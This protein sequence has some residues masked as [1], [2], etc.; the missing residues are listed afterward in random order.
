M[1]DNNENNDFND[2]EFDENGFDPTK[3]AFFSDMEEMEEEIGVEAY[4]LVAHALSLIDSKFFDD[5]IEVLRQAVGLYDQI[6]KVAEIEAIRNKISEI[7]IL[8]EQAFTEVESQAEEEVKTEEQEIPE[9]IVIQEIEEE[10]LKEKKEADLDYS[11]EDLINEANQLVEIDEFDEALDRYDEA[12]RIFEDSNNNSKIER[13]NKLIEEC[14]KAKASLLKVAKK[15]P[16]KVEMPVE[17]EPA[18]IISKDKIKE[19]RV[20]EFEE[21]K[22]REEQLSNQALELMGQALEKAKSVQY[23][24]AIKLYEDAA[25]LFEEINW[26]NE[27]TKVKATIGKIRKEKEVYLQRLEAEREER[28]KAAE[29]KRKEA[30]LLAKKAEERKIKEEDEK[31][32]KFEELGA[33]K[34]EEEAF[35]KLISNM[36]DNAEKRARDYELDIKKGKFDIKCPYEELIGIYEYIRK[37]LIDKG[38]NDQA[39]IYTKQVKLLHEKLEKDIKLRKIEAQKAQKQK[40]YDELYK[41]P[42]K[43]KQIGLDIERLKQ[44]EEQK[45]IDAEREVFEVEMSKK[46][47]DAERICRD[48]EIAIRKGKFETKCPYPEIIETYDNI[49]AAFQ[50]RGNQD[51]IMIYNN[52]INVTKQRLEKDNKLREI[53]AK[54][55]QKQKEYDELFKVKK[56]K[57]V[58]IDEEKLKAAEEQYKKELEEQDFINEIEKMAEDAE[59]MA[60]EYEVVIRKGK[61]ETICPYQE[62]IETYED[63]KEAFQERGNIDQISIYNNIINIIRGKLEKDNKLREIEAQKAKKQEEYEELYKGKKEVKVGL[64]EERL[65]VLE[66]QR[67]KELDEEN[68]RNEIEKMVSK[69]ERMAREYEVQ[70][71]KGKF[72]T[73]CVYADIINIFENIVNIVGKRGW[74][75]E[76][77]IYKTQI[78]RYNEKLEKDNKLREIEAKK[79]EKDRA[80]KELYK[81][82][83]VAKVGLDEERLKVL[84]EQRQ[85]ELDEENFRNEIEKMIMNAEKMAREYEVQI[86]KGNFEQECVYSEIMNTFENIVNIVSERGWQDEA[87]IY[88][89]QIR[90]YK[91]KLE[92]DNKLRKIEAQ[93]LQKQKDFDELHKIKEVDTIRAVIKSLDREEQMLDVFEK[94]REQNYLTDKAMTVIDDAEKLV[95]NYELKIKKEIFLYDSPYEEVISLYKE[96]RK[97]FI[98]ADWRDEASRLIATIKFYM[99][100][101][102]KDDKLRDLEESKREKAK[103]EAEAMKVQPRKD[104]IEKKK[105]VLELEHRKKEKELESDEIF[106]MINE[107]ERLVKEYELTIKGGEILQYECPYE[108][109]IKIYREAKKRLGDIGWKDEANRLNSSINF[110]KQKLERDN[111]L[112]EVERKKIER[113]EMFKEIIKAPVKA[114][115]IK[116]EMKKLELKKEKSK[117]DVVASETFKMIDEAEK[118]V[119]EYELK[120]KAGTFLECPYESIIETYREARKKFEEIGWKDQAANL[121]NT[122]NHYK[123]KLAQDNKLRAIEAEKIA[124]EQEL[125]KGQQEIASKAR[126]QQMEMRKRKEEALSLQQRKVSETER[127]RNEAFSL[128]DKAKIEFNKQNF[129]EALELYTKSKEYFTQLDWQEGISMVSGSITLIKKKKKEM[130]LRQEAAKAKEAEKIEIEK[131]LEAKFAKIKDLKKI[132]EAKKKLELKKIQSEK[133]KEKEASDQAYQLLEQGTTL[134]GKKKFDEAQKKYINAR[135]IF[136]ELNWTR[137]VSRINNDLLFKLRREKK[138]FEGLKDLKKR[139]LEEKRVKDEL[140]KQSQIDKKESARK[141]IQEK[142]RKLKELEVTK[143]LDKKL[144]DTLDTANDF[145]NRGYYNQGIL[146]FEEVIT[147][148]EKK[149]LNEEVEKINNQINSVKSEAQLPLIISEELDR[150]ENMEKFKNAYKSIDNAQESILDGN[151]MKSISE[152]NEAKHNLKETKL[153]EKYIK[154]IDEKIKFCREELQKK[155]KKKAEPAKEIKKEELPEELT[156]DVAYNYMD[157]ANK[158]ERKNNFEKAV[159]FATMAR[160]IF[161]KL[162]LEWSREQAS[163]SQHIAI[164]KNKQEARKRLFTSAQEKREEKEEQLKSEEESKAK[165]EA[166]RAERRKRIQELMEKRSQNQK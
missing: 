123:T 18:E 80:Y 70:I 20:K 132:E 17:T 78:R 109:I 86:R 26:I 4:D 72:D 93:K 9:E 30:K 45:A 136:K 53:E 153:G 150:N 43:E 68:F 105:K 88:K 114:D 97:L 76:V 42:T 115:I 156:A 130:E 84:E 129:D 16:L 75:D 161:V 6:N 118:S 134:L 35:Q 64:D 32:K 39:V 142:R 44:F 47:D 71:R 120:L 81:G 149:G 34:L 143:S 126:A 14:Y 92:R 162:G 83:K 113:A 61:F 96:A 62:I 57:K 125:L 91:E 99:D 56:E 46:V 112:R 36:V 52:L 25:K 51:Q 124:K 13:V 74:Q 111:K 110:Y 164:L 63:I 65:K 107:A 77:A 29:M 33:K 89:T 82:K 24:D 131:K 166:R 66:E 147:L 2:E 165:I 160:D 67:Q 59:K 106:E 60:R 100:K 135:D 58:G 117:E 157:K 119:K 73:E 116:Q 41:A 133:A 144:R 28:E 152:L 22:K 122:I 8:K 48:Y 158:E 15:E 5:A 101:K 21:L 163:I 90:K 95:K 141:K 7:Y 121:I 151:Y 159:E 154:I 40:E 98:E 155:R 12:I 10:V 138:K 69:T 31:I 137:E 108:N 145:V 94:K 49:R 104:L 148:M 3:E 146:K 87:A 23:D 19:Q 140:F 139:K 1:G 54:K 11:V 85:K 38:W 128:M 102:E 79:T 50:E 103:L 55:A 127:V 27:V 37:L